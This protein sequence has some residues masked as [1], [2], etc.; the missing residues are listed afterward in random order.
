M[1]HFLPALV[2][3]VQL[4][5]ACQ[6]EV[7]SRRD[8]QDNHN[9]HIEP[10]EAETLPPIWTREEH[11]LHDSFSKVEMDTWASYYTRGDHLAGRNKSMAEATAKTWREN[12]IP[13]SL[14][15]YHV[16]LDY[17]KQQEL[18][19]TW[20]NGSTYEAQMYED[21]LEEDDTTGDPSAL[22]GFHA[23]SANGIV[24][25]EYVYVG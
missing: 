4:S 22:P 7:R 24:E 12:G 18:V 16:F 8:I 11:F 19:L 3:F 23:F 1:P 2:A 17:P 6:R 15:E 25:A 9:D 21:I 20:S 10:R 14:V 13:A 5:I